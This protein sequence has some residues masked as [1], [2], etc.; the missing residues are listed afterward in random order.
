MSHILSRYTLS[1]DRTGRRRTEFGLLD[2]VYLR[3]PHPEVELQRGACGTVVEVFDAP[4]RAYEVEF[5]DA[6]GRTLAQITL[7]PT[8]LSAAPLDPASAR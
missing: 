2:V 3:V 8:E 1:T 5:S 4:R 6:R 7:D